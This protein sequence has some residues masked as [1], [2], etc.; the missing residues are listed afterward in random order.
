MMATGRDTDL[1]QKFALF[2]IRFTYVVAKREIELSW[3]LAL[4]NR[5]GVS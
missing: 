5:V 1:H 4:K 3:R 2:I